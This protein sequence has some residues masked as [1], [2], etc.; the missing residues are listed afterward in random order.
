MVVSCLCVLLRDA[1]REP[2]DR[3]DVL[4]DC[5]GCAVADFALP[6]GVS[7]TSLHQSSMAST[8]SSSTTFFFVDFEPFAVAFGVTFAA[9]AFAV[10]FAAVVSFARF[11]LGA[12][13]CNRSAALASL[14]SWWPTIF[15]CFDAGFAVPKTS[16]DAS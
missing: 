14:R 7:G 3:E 15:A 1:R 10:A 8:S 9:V 16:S 12:S 2:V 5:A 6:I 4:D 11:P 13:V